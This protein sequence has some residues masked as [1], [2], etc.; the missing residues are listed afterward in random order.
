[1]KRT[2]HWC[3]ERAQH[4]DELMVNEGWNWPICH[5][6]KWG[7]SQ[8]GQNI[9]KM[10]GCTLAFIYSIR[11]FYFMIWKNQGGWSLHSNCTIKRLT[12]IKI[13]NPKVMVYLK[14]ECFFVQ[15]SFQER[16]CVSPPTQVLPL[17]YWNSPYLPR[18]ACLPVSCSLW[19]GRTS[20]WS[21]M[22]T[23]HY[24]YLSSIAKHQ[25]GSLWLV[26]AVVSGVSCQ[27]EAVR[28]RAGHH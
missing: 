18:H 6:G 11:C 15:I 23:N 8:R 22:M 24:G 28:Y 2:G 16:W 12:C 1:M 17:G 9:G 14:W 13:I 25:V 26:W 10:P 5:S 3:L 20:V 21:G 7:N 19:G 4:T 27:S